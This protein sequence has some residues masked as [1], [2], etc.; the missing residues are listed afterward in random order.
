MLKIKVYTFSYVE[1]L[2]CN[3]PLLRGLG[4]P[5]AI[6]STDILPIL[7]P[8]VTSI[9]SRNLLMRTTIHFTPLLS[10]RNQELLIQTFSRY[11]RE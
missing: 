3:I 7:I 5:F 10:W 2:T 4:V 1:I 8:T 9:Y 6:R 11:G